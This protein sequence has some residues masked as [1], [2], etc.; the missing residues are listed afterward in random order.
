MVRA[1]VVS[2]PEQWPHAGYNEIQ[3]PRRKS[4]LI[5]YETLGHLSG[6]NNFKDFQSAHHRWVQSEL[7]DDG[8]KREECWTQS[9][10][11]GSRSFVETVKREMGSFA[12]GRRVQKN[13]DGFEL[14]ES[15]SSYKAV[16]DAEKDDIDD[17]NLWFWN[18]LNE[19]SEC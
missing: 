1:G 17:E 8:A 15:P 7:S 2:H 12:I 18:E 14:R 9:I 13:V 10:A 16:F 6:F 4:I 11:T 19:I 3:H 5:D